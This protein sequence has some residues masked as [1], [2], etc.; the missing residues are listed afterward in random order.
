MIWRAA[1]ARKNQRFSGATEFVFKE[2][3]HTGH[4]SC[5][6]GKDTYYCGSALAVVQIAQ[7]MARKD[8]EWIECIAPRSLRRPREE[9]VVEICER[10]IDIASALFEISGREL[11]EQGRSNSVVSRVR[12]IAMYVAHVS[13]GLTMKEVGNG[14]ARDRTTV[15]YA[16]HVIEDMRDD[17]EFD[18]VVGTAEKIAVAALR[19]REDA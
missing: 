14:F 12:Q 7:R 4:A 15:M 17:I 6:I 10:M 5:D 2:S 19:A 9:H 18:R 8:R 11:R 3:I 13:L 16:C 1:I